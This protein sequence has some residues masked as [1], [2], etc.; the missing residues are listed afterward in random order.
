M[1]ATISGIPQELIDAIIEKNHADK[2]TLQA[3]SLVSR[4]WTYSSQRRIFSHISFNRPQS[5]YNQSSRSRG[6]RDIERFNSFI[7]VHPHLATLVKSVEISP[8]LNAHHLRTMLEKLV[9]LES[10]YLHLCG[11]SW[12]ELS[13][14]MRNTL[15]TAFRSLR[16]TLLEI[17]DGLFLHYPDFLALL[18]TCQYLKCLLLSAVSCEDLVCCGN[19]VRSTQLP[20]GG[21]ELQLHSLALSSCE[22]P[23]VMVQ[24]LQPLINISGLQRL[25][26]LTDGSGGLAK[27]T[28]VTKEILRLLNGSSLEHLVLNVCLAE[29]LSNLIDISHI[30]SMRIKL[31]WICHQQHT[32]PVEWLRWLTGL[33]R[34]LSKWHRL[35][36]VTL[37]IFYESTITS[38]HGDDWTAL[39][40]TLGHIESLKRVHLGLDAYDSVRARWKHL[41]EYPGCVA[42]D[43][44]NVLPTLA[45]QRILSVEVAANHPG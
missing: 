42:D 33:F 35:E 14:S 19:L 13:P 21:L 8:L 26:V 27:R 9:N 25:S 23:S 45:K 20:N 41:R 44:R 39:D 5:C 29:P 12:D 3:C 40:A 22:T 36:E 7:S 32:Q 16:L 43:V 17:R 34:D 24:L 6:C 2:A 11:Y 30:R 37:E 38:Y 18:T 4:S 1:D 15:I 10:I 31:W 28:K